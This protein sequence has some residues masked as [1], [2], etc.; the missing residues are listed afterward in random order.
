MDNKH[1]NECFRKF[2][3]KLYS[4]KVDSDKLKEF[5]FLSD[6]DIPQLSEDQAN[7]LEGPVTL[8]E[9]DAAILSLQSGK[10]PEADGFPVEFFLKVL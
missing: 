4:S 3:E 5:Q 7:L 2:K 6:L 8:S 10:S 9:I 1:I